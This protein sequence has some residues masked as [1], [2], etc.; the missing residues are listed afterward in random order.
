MK[1]A[2]AAVLDGMH[3]IECS[4]LYQGDFGAGKKKMLYFKLV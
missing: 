1:W 3:K 2:Q 4:K